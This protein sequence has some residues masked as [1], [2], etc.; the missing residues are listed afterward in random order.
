[1]EG[2]C[3]KNKYLWNMTSPRGTLEFHI[4][5]QGNIY[6]KKFVSVSCIIKS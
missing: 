2:M 4:I 1:M 3:K 5:F 6:S